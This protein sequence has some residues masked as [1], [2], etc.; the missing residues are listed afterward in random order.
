MRAK[1]PSRDSIEVSSPPLFLL[2]EDTFSPVK[3][4]ANW[5]NSVKKEVAP[6]RISPR[7][8]CLVDGKESINK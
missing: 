2:T 1:R 3:A 8:E 5:W 4:Y 6:A 7:M